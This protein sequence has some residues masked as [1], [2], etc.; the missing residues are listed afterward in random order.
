MYRE[1]GELWFLSM[2]FGVGHFDLFA[3]PSRTLRL[4]FAFACP[5]PQ[6]NLLPRRPNKFCLFSVPA[7]ATSRCQD[8]P[9]GK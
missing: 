9:T 5:Q 4:L 2:R 1:A 7:S 8:R 3:Y 6:L